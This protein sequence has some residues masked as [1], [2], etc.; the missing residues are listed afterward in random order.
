[1]KSMQE[2][3]SIITYMRWAVSLYLST[4]YMPSILICYQ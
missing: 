1:M 2:S 4:I 3:F